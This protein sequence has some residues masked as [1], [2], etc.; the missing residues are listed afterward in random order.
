MAKKYYNQEEIKTEKENLKK[1]LDQSIVDQE[2]EINSIDVK[3]VTVELERLKKD[4]R[5]DDDLLEGVRASLAAK[6]GK[7]AANANDES[8]AKEKKLS[9]LIGKADDEA[10]EK[11]KT[12][13]SVYGEAKKNVEND[14]LKRGIARSS[15]ANGGVAEI[16]R[17][18]VQ[19][20]DEIEKG[21]ADKKTSL[22]AQIDA[23]KGELERLLA[24]YDEE[25]AAEEVED[26][27]KAVKER[28]KTNEEVIKYNNTLAEKEQKY[29]DEDMEAAIE[30]QKKTLTEKYQI[31]RLNKVVDYYRGF[32][33][34]TRALDD[35]LADE[36]MRKYLGG[37][38]NTAL[39][40]IYNM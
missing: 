31:E 4:E 7:L 36:S 27:N 26:F 13:E 16:E 17:G 9:E 3:P 1:T 8:A 39:R 21:A 20:I 22:S 12:V 32:P 28:D 18:K 14:A 19:S 25:R 37:F 29:I 6:Y 38:Y 11:K 10:A 33:S 30:K 40:L 24:Q 15:I 35:F 23:L 2:N 34:V 5:T